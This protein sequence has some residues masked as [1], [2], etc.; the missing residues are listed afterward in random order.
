MLV[1]AIAV[2]VNSSPN[3]LFILLSILTRCNNHS[4]H[5]TQANNNNQ[6]Q[7][8]RLASKNSCRIAIFTF[9][10]LST[11]CHGTV[12]K[13]NV[14]MKIQFE[15]GTLVCVVCS[16]F[17]PWIYSVVLAIRWIQISYDDKSFYSRFDYFIFIDRI[18]FLFKINML[19]CSN[20]L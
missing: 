6:R 2:A 9:C 11:L 4:T 18:F 8:C 5:D 20:D 12:N 14:L 17:F 10:I 3:W 19:Q 15:M 13:N 7:K 16:F 1:T